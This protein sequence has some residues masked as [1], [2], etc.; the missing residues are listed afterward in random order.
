MY[1]VIKEFSRNL[2]SLQFRSILIPFKDLSGN[3]VLCLTLLCFWA[4]QR[5]LSS[6]VHPSLIT[7]KVAGSEQALRVL[8]SKERK[9]NWPGVCRINTVHDR[10]HSIHTGGTSIL[11]KPRLFLHIHL[12]CFQRRLRNPYP[13]YTLCTILTKLFFM[14]RHGLISRICLFTQIFNFTSWHRIYFVLLLL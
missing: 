3:P 7:S 10:T 13:Q 1:V 5:T 12:E 11:P 2:A 4:P 9:T 6:T 8:Y 14:R